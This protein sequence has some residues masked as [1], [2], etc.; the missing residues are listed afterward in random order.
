ML[1]SQVS[2][3]DGNYW[4]GQDKLF[5]TKS[6]FGNTDNAVKDF[7][8]SQAG[9]VRWSLLLCTSLLTVC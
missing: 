9:A 4:K 6:M 2:S 1:S 8:S 3:Q 5:C 7:E